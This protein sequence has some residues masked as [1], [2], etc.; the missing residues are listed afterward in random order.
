MDSDTLVT[1]LAASVGGMIHI[2][3]NI[4]LSIL[5]L[6]VTKILT[7]IISWILKRAAAKSK[8]HFTPLMCGF[9]T[10]V[11]KV[12]AYIFA[13][14]MIFQIWGINL[15][16]VIAGLGVT[17]VIL[18][19]A[20]QESISNVFSGLLL[21]INNPFAL[22]DFVQIGSIEGTV[23]N[24]DAITV[25]LLSPDRKKITISNKLVLEGAIVNY[26]ASD[27]RRIDMTVPVAYGS[28]LALVKKTIN[29]VL[30]SY[31]EVLADPAPIVE[32]HNLEDNNVLFVARPFVKNA[33][34]WKLKWRFQMDIIRTFNEKGIRVPPFN[35]VDVNIKSPK[36]D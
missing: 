19:F 7:M 15:A 21:A 32:V 26:S 4:G 13:I 24:M 9:V 31:S 12:V 17:G 6:L 3:V 8:E 25:T 20:L 11:I 30:T 34:Y 29:E 1:T 5:T 28:D 33:D 10:K 16:P 14:L 36:A 35:Q 27:I 22:G 23:T 18:G 2:F